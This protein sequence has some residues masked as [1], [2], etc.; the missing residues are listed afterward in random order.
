MW[1]EPLCYPCQKLL[2]VWFCLAQPCSPRAL[3]PKTLNG[4]LEKKPGSLPTFLAWQEKKKKK[5]KAHDAGHIVKNVWCKQGLIDLGIIFN[6][7]ALDYALLLNIA[8]FLNG[9][10]T[11]WEA[12]AAVIDPQC[13]LHHLIFVQQCPHLER[14]IRKTTCIIH[15][16]WG[17]GVELSLSTR[18]PMA[19]EWRSPPRGGEPRDTSVTLPSCVMSTFRK[20]Q[21]GRCSRDR[22]L[23]LVFIMQA[24]SL[25]DQTSRRSTLM[26]CQDPCPFWG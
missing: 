23:V 26:Q 1:T 18:G 13:V 10:R 15:L 9:L 14:R 5:K 25:A 24:G 7:M 6:K 12:E 16:S 11:G 17:G 4:G 2:M 22:H 20:P 8:I 21:Q 19:E 3:P